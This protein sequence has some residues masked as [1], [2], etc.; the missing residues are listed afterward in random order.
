MGDGVVAGVGVTFG[1][2]LGAG[3]GV[4]LDAAKLSDARQTLT[5]ARS[6][7]TKRRVVMAKL[8]TKR[9]RWCTFLKRLAS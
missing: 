5:A 1:V 8:E 4:D 9:A 3:V 7:A 2:G 6:E